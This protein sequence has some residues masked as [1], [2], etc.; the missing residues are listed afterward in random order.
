MLTHNMVVG[1]QK[2]LPP[3]GVCKGCVLGKHHQEHFDSMNSW[4]VL[5]LL[6]LVHGDVCCINK[7]SLA[8]VRYVLT[9][10]D[11]LS[12]YNWVYFLNNKIHVFER[13]KE[14]RALDEKKCDRPI[15]CFRSNNGREYV[16]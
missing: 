12:H 13:F 7:S 5:N 6:E 2:V 8:G 15:K 4:C 9:F 14:F 11:D 3:N 1:L 10:T 16:T